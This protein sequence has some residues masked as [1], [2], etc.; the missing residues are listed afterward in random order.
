MVDFE[1]IF[2]S[3]YESI[4]ERGLPESSQ[5]STHCGVSAALL[6]HKDAEIVAKHILKMS[7]TVEEVI[8]FYGAE[9]KPV[10][11]RNRPESV[12]AA[13]DHLSAWCAV[14]GQSFIALLVIG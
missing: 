8:L 9:S 3:C 6:E 5:L 1:L 2:A 7:L 10:E 13:G 12:V 11:W 14:V 4:F